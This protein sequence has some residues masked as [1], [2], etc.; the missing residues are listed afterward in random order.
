MACKYGLFSV[1]YGLLW[2]IV[3]HC[4]GLLGVPGRFFLAP[5]VREMG[6]ATV[7]GPSTW[8]LGYLQFYGKPLRGAF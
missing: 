6:V 7:S 3:A 8:R 5:A 1:N 2:G 4:F